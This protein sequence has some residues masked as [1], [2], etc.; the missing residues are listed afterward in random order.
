M[1]KHAIVRK[2]PDSY[3]SCLSS[4][5]L[6]NELNINK[7]REQHTKYVQLLRD[8]GLEVIILP[9][10]D[11]QPDCCFVEDTAIIYKSKAVITYMGAPSRRG[12]V[13]SIAEIL[14]EHFSIKYISKPATIEGG[15]VV[16]FPH[17][18]ISGISQRTNEAGLTQTSSFL[19]VP[20]KAIKDP[21]I[22]HLKSYVSYL[23]DQTVLVTEKYS[24]DKSL[25]NLKKIIVPKNEAYAA[26]VLYVNDT[27]IIPDGYPGTKHLLSENSFDVI[28]LQTSEIAKCDGALT[29]L[30]LLF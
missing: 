5:P 1:Y 26:N 10:L 7:A 24:N 23:D 12:E 16:H 20:I 18:L 27:I 9:A 11:T 19:D 13:D 4:H 28:I 30:S 17:F 3:V 8:L 22:M 25:D 15:D 6:H 2:I 29:C 21:S 14:K